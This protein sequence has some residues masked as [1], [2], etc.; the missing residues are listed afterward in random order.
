MK[1]FEICETACG[2]Y[3]PG[4]SCDYGPCP[5]LYEYKEKIKFVMDINMSERFPIL[6]KQTNRQVM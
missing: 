2:G 1:T 5:F 3:E 4:N 6:T